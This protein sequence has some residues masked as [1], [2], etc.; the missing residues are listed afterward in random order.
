MGKLSKMYGPSITSISARKRKEEWVKGLTAGDTSTLPTEAAVEFADPVT[1]TGTTTIQEEMV[2]TDS[3]AQRVAELE[4]KLAE[5][6]TALARAEA[7]A[8]KHDPR[9]DVPFLD[10]P[11]AYL[12]YVGYEDLNELAVSSLALENVKRHREGKPPL[13]FGPDRIDQEVQR[14]I[15]KR[16]QGIRSNV[17]GEDNMRVLK[18]VKPSG[19][20][21][22]IPVETQIN[23]E[24]GQQGAAI[25]KARE[26]GFKIAYP[27]RCY[28]HNCWDL[29]ATDDAGN[30][31]LDGYCSPEHRAGDPYLNAK[32]VAGMST[33]AGAMTST[34]DAGRA[35]GYLAR[36]G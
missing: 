30:I 25:W 28:R 22:Q 12:E 26:K 23:N 24:A 34:R 33:S 16:I 35:D 9:V 21:T 19:T 7:E 5:T 3:S 20:M 6:E 13:E 27:Y 32:P 14:I 36:S 11:E 8:R 2:P 10:T 18:M 15:T 29:A 17:R 31:V 1:V 4:A